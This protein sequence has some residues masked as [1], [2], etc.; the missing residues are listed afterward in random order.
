MQGTRKGEI[1][2]L[3]YRLCGAV[4]FVCA[5][6]VVIPPYFEAAEYRKFFDDPAAEILAE[7]RAERTTRS[8][9]AH[10]YHTPDGVFDGESFDVC[11]LNGCS[12][13]E[14]LNA[15]ADAALEWTGKRRVGFVRFLLENSETGEILEPAFEGEHTLP[16]P[17]GEYQIYLVGKHFCGRLEFSG[18]NLQAER[19]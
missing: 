10:I 7:H 13:A 16:L 15:G 18:E 5:S 17:E 6:A 8:S 19:N 9:T 2:E 3:L 4:G 12:P 1:K 11:W 14:T